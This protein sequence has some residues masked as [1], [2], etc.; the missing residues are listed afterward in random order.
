VPIV[1]G[2]SP[3]TTALMLAAAVVMGLLVLV[4][5]LGALIR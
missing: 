3:R 4:F 2:S 5:V 1:F